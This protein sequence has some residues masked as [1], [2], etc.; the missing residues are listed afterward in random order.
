MPAEMHLS[1]G[2]EDYSPGSGKHRE[3]W[4]FRTAKSHVLIVLGDS[5]SSAK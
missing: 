1:V 4:R 2:S 3:I 5:P